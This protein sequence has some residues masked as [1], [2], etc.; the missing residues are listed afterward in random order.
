MEIA[1]DRIECRKIGRQ[2]RKA[3]EI[4]ESELFGG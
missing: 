2:I 3:I 4:E 1:E